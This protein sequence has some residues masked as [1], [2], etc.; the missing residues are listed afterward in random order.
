MAK[1][2]EQLGYQIFADGTIISRSGKPLIGG[3]DKKGY[4]R[5]CIS[6]NGSQFTL[7]VHRVIAEKFIPN[8]ENKPQVNHKDGNKLNN[9]VDNLEW[10]TNS[11]N[12][13]HAWST[14]LNKISQFTIS[15]IRNKNSKRVLN[16]ETGECFLNSRIACEKLGLNYNTVRAKLNGNKRNDTTL[17]YYGSA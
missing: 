16:T 5:V 3:I 4:K 1:N 13:L 17:M 11:E 10:V 12:Q 2:I 14:G 7:K 15:A 6:D 9:C 8:P